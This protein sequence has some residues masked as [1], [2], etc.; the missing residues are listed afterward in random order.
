MAKES[1]AELLDTRGMVITRAGESVPQSAVT[2]TPDSSTGFFARFGI[3][4]SNT[5]IFATP[6]E[7]S[8]LD[9]CR[10]FW[11]SLFPVAAV[12]DLTPGDAN[13]SAGFAHAGYRIHAA[14]SFDT[15]RHQSW[16][17][18]HRDATVY[19][20][21]TTSI[22]ADP[23]SAAAGLS[24]LRNAQTPRIVTISS[25]DS[26]VGLASDRER[27]DPC[28]MGRLVAQ[29]S[30]LN[31]DFIV[32]TLPHSA[33]GG[34]GNL[35]DSVT[36]TVSLLLTAGYSAALRTV[37]RDSMLLLAA[38]GRTKPQW[39]DDTLSELQDLTEP[40]ELERGESGDNQGKLG[41][42]RQQPLIT[43]TSP[44]GES[45]GVLDSTSVDGLLTLE[46]EQTHGS[47]PIK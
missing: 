19:P 23:E 30:V 11:F 40:L 27:L 18:Q 45:P 34:L 38:P 15:E 36:H 44:S 39:I 10:S 1:D 43:V 32:L 8:P 12:L 37:S 9:Q 21:N 28:E 22:I 29:S 4:E 25:G 31:A 14:I 35:R 2:P 5:I 46:G 26:A 42:L 3:Q 33:L 47:T 20:G 6:L 13:L 24:E 17:V 41:D 16:K 7:P